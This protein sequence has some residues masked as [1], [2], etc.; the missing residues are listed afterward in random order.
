[1]SIFVIK[2]EKNGSVIKEW[3]LEGNEDLVRSFIEMLNIDLQ[4]INKIRGFE[5]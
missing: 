4:F 2:F 3:V 1:M 5:K